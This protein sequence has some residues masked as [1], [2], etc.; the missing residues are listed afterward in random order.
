M[1]YHTPPLDSSKP[2]PPGEFINQ[3]LLDSSPA[4]LQKGSNLNPAWGKP[5]TNRLC[6]ITTSDVHGLRTVLALDE[7]R[8]RL[9]LSFLC[10]PF[11]CGTEPPHVTG[12]TWE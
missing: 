3:P 12:H 7:L 11:M 10:S 8:H 5:N 1:N 6:A 4:P 2:P 9:L